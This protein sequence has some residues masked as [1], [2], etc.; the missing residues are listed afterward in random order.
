MTK[1]IIIFGILLVIFGG[2]L[3]YQY[4]SQ[5]S[6][7]MK[8]NGSTVTIGNHPFAVEVVKTDLDRQ[9]G[10]TKYQAI[11]SN[12]GMLFLFDTPG[13]YTFWMKGMKFPI[14]IIFIHDDTI[15]SF[16]ENATVTS[17]NDPQP[18]T[19]KPESSANKVLE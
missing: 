16:V 19:Y 13:F 14:D 18:L 4:G 6:S 11:A 15:V 12:Q 10:L 8:T 5:L 2:F 1:V 7:T 17:P 9:I 3:F